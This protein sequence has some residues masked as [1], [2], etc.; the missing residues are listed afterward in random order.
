VL[1]VARHLGRLGLP[2]PARILHS[3]KL[4]ARQTAEILAEGLSGPEPRAAPGLLPL[5]PIAETVEGVSL[6][7]EDLALVGHLPFVDRLA[8]RLVTGREGSA[9]DFAPG[10]VL[11]LSR[12]GERFSVRWMLTPGSS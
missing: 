1:R 5:D 10:A 11:C 4:R 3:G 2:A 9:F 12:S 6:E 8:T 7:T